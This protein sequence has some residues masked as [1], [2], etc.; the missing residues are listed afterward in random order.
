M[1]IVFEDLR[2]GWP[3]KGVKSYFQPE[4]TSEILTIADLPHAVS[5]ISTCAG[6][7]FRPCRMKMCCSDNH[8]TTA[9]PM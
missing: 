4:P 2:N 3:T 9:P 1:I 6:P 5:R 8:F 7:K